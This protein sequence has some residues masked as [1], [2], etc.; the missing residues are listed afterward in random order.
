MWR[1]NIHKVNKKGDVIKHIGISQSLLGALTIWRAMEEK[2]LPPYIPDWA[3]NIADGRNHFRTFDFKNTGAIQDLWDLPNTG[4]MEEGDKH[5]LLST[6][7]NC[8]VKRENIPRLIFSY[9]AFLWEQGADFKSNIDK[10]LEAIREIYEDE[11]YIAICR[12]QTS[13]F[14]QRYTVIEDEETGEVIEERPYNIYK[15]SSHWFLYGDEEEDG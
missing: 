10:Q 7:D 6:Y 8:M 3:R 4:D 5:V 14:E 13:V 1:T 9:M 12:D 15:D 11:E 2:Y